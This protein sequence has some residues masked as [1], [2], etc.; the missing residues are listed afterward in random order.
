MIFFLIIL[1]DLPEKAMVPHSSTLAWKI[2][3]QRSL[4]GCCPW[5]HREPDMTEQLHFHLSLS[6]IGEGNGTPLQCSCLENPRDWGAWWA[7]LYGVSQSQTW[8]KRLSSSSSSSLTLTEAPVSIKISSF[9]NENYD[10][11]SL[12]ISFQVTQIW[13]NSQHFS[14]I[15]APPATHM[16]ACCMLS[17]FSCVWLFLTLWTEDCQAPLSMGFSG[18][19]SW[20]G[21]AF[22]P[23]GHLPDPEF[24]PV[25]V[26]SSALADG[27]FT[28][29]A[30]WEAQI[31]R[32]KADRHKCRS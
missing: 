4:V 19:E 29:G 20:S 17:H 30:T 2:P 32:P 11:A 13:S 1:F 5:G 7:A 22:P 15:C 31:A 26:E 16:R 27:F 6:C 28:S 12:S 8:L 23:P 25:S 24:K 10:V 18:Q 21:L 3:W 9:T 14:K